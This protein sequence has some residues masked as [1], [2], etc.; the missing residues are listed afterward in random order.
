MKRS[1]I[2]LTIFSVVLVNLETILPAPASP[3]GTSDNLPG[4]E[5]F[6]LENEK[7]SYTL[8]LENGQVF[9]DRLERKDNWLPGTG[10]AK[11]ILETNADFAIDLMWTGWR[12]PGKES[13]ADNLVSLTRKDFQ[14]AGA[15]S[16]MLPDGTRELTLFF[17]GNTTGLDLRINYQLPPQAFYIRRNLAVADSVSGLHF[18]HQ[19]WP[20]HSTIYNYIELIKNGGFGQPV[21]CRTGEG[22]VFFG[23]EYPASR[24]EIMPG[25]DGAY[26]VCCGQEA[27]VKISKEWISSDWAVSGLS[28]DPYVKLWFNRYL[29]QVRVAP[30][31]PYLKYNCWCDVRS[32]ESVDNPEAVMNEEN[33]FRIIKD[34]RRELYDKRGISLDAFVLDDG[35]DVYK[36]DWVLRTAEFPHGLKPF[37]DTLRHMGTRL[38]IWFGPIG[39]YSFREQRVGWMKDHGYEVT[40]DQLCLAGKNYYPLFADRVLGFMQ[41]DHISHFKWDGILF[42][43]SE[44]EHGHPTGI[45][46]RR[47][48]TDSLILLCNK[49]RT[50]N[51]GVYLNI[52][53]GTWLSPWWLK[54]TNTIWMQGEDWGYSSVPS[55]SLRDMETTF[56]DITLYNDFRK[57]DFWFPV[58]NLMT[59]GIIKGRLA[60]LGGESETLEQFT[61]NAVFCLAR[62]VAMWELYVSPDMLTRGEWDAIASTIRWARDRF[63]ILRNTEMTGGD[64]AREEAYGYLHFSGDHGILACRNSSADIRKMNLELDPSFGLDPEVD[65]LVI[66]RVFPSRWIYPGYFSPGDR[67]EISLDGFETAIYEIYPLQDATYPLIAGVNFEVMNTEGK[68]IALELSDNTGHVTILNPQKIQN[69]WHEGKNIT[70]DGLSGILAEP[71]APIRSHSFRSE[72]IKNK[73][74]T[75][76]TLDIDQSVTRAVLSALFRSSGEAD[77]IDPVV[78][79]LIDSKQT[80]PEII[81][82]DGSWAWYKVNVTAGNHRVRILAEIPGKKSQWKGSMSAWLQ[83][84]QSMKG[85]TLVFDMTEKIIERLMPPSPNNPGELGINIKLGQADLFLFP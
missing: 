20:L 43:C 79:I 31:R 57:N 66:E 25:S 60:N 65:S 75:N 26:Q 19:L 71:D 4:R 42:S 50:E 9:S 44:P 76:M 13:N 49:V 24:N 40:G 30:V 28:T 51:P 16:G 17:A 69:I 5:T 21:A 72:I 80:V 47:A 82:Q 3:N 11:V 39:G 41:N 83:G 81:R 52:T 32:A 62:G 55:A 59:V 27:G 63:E 6:V 85:E 54:Y 37:A 53:S 8:V 38:G 18:L 84:N 68:K 45:N 48:I 74:V 1:R 35:W 22:G 56:R 23:L 12:A 73:S 64:P 78:T 7:V 70:A 10:T 2:F 61:N 29:D 58:S 14:L 67:T 46:S 77:T 34:F 33:I 36:S 15:Q